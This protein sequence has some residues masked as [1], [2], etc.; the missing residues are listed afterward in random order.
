MAKIEIR[1]PACPGC[2]IVTKLK[3]HQEDFAAWKAGKLIQDAFPY[4]S[5]PEREALKTGYC[6]TCWN[7]FIASIN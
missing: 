2:R 4:L 5:D 1:S 6:P 7:I 3:V